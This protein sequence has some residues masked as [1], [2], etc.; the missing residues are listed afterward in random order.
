MTINFNLVIGI[1]APSTV[2]G[3]SGAQNDFDV[4]FDIKQ[5]HR[6]VVVS[7][8]SGAPKEAKFDLSRLPKI[9]SDG[10]KLIVK[11]QEDLIQK[12]LKKNAG[13]TIK[14]DVSSPS[15]QQSMIKLFGEVKEQLTFDEYYFLIRTSLNIANQIAGRKS[16]QV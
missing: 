9:V 14:I 4:K 15:M 5:P 2:S 16:L 10:Y 13:K 8:S 1:S 6:D 3:E 11:K 12:I 7:K